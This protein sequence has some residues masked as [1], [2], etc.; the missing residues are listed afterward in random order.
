ML[1]GRIITPA[2]IWLLAACSGAS[3]HDVVAPEPQ[4]LRVDVSRAMDIVPD[5]TRML[6]LEASPKSLLFSIDRLFA[7]GDSYV[8]AS[9]TKLRSYDRRTGKYLGDVAALNDSESGYTNLSQ[10]WV[11][12]DTL[13]VFDCNAR[14]VG[15]YLADGSFLGKTYPFVHSE[16]RVNQP[17]RMFFTMASGDILTVNGSTGGSTRT[18]PLLSHYGPGGEYR[19]YVPGRDVR[20]ST[21]LMDGAWQDRECDRLQLWEPLRDT[22]YAATPEGISPLYVLDAGANSFP[23]SYRNLELIQDRL[24]RFYRSG[25][26]A[27]YVSVMRYLQAQGEVLY[28]CLAG[29]DRRNYVVRY[30]C[31]TDSAAIASVATPDGRYTASTFLALDGDSLL[32]ELRDNQCVEANPIIYTIDKNTLR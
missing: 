31:A 32:L 5:T 27:T 16:V 19:K 7:I 20:E 15:R 13:C 12:G 28:F 30:D 4:L 3:G 9:R 6:R 24:D 26:S 17:L 22:V 14:S 8:V 18:N 29:S 23:E 10:L 21:Y 25:D 1:A 2:A 11:E